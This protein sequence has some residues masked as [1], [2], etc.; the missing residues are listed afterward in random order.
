MASGNTVLY[1][2]LKQILYNDSANSGEAA[3]YGIGLIM[4]G[5]ANPV[6]IQE[7]I[8]YAHDTQH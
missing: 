8:T 6:A 5:T 7:M 1:E 2:H 4:L 3:S